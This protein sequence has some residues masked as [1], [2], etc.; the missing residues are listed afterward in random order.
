M[1]STICRDR[2]ADDVLQS[3]RDPD[4]CEGNV[5]GPNSASR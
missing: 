3:R 2:S 5:W 4:R 1:S